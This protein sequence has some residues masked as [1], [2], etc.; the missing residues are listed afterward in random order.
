MCEALTL[1]LSPDGERGLLRADFYAR[2]TRLFSAT[3]FGVWFGRS[4]VLPFRNIAGL[5]LRSDSKSTRSGRSQFDK[6]GT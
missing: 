1:T 3:E 6:R 4:F 2:L 5:A